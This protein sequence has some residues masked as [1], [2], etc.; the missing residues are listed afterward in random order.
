[1]LHGQAEGGHMFTKI[2]TNVHAN[3]P[4]D[5]NRVLTLVLYNIAVCDVDD[6]VEKNPSA[7]Q[8][9][10]GTSKNIY[11]Q[12]LWMD[13]KLEIHLTELIKNLSKPV[14]ALQSVWVRTEPKEPYTNSHASLC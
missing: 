11:N 14:I 7:L 8:G 13:R 9:P 4:F 12:R 10:N 2:C 1:M 5:E 3:K 6:L